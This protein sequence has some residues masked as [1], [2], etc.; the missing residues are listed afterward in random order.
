M[1]ARDVTPG[2]RCPAC[3][4]EA[5]QRHRAFSSACPWVD[6]LLEVFCTGLAE[7]RSRALLTMLAPCTTRTR[8]ERREAMVAVSA[9]VSEPPAARVRNHLRLVKPEPSSA[10]PARRTH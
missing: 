1:S 6:E 5:R 8:E 7:P 2:S 10:A 4:E 9:P 3:C